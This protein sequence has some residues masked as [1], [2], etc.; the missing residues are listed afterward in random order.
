[1]QCYNYNKYNI[2]KGKVLNLK[3]LNLKYIKCFYYYIINDKKN[4]AYYKYH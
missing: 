4:D 2:I 3:T 1:M